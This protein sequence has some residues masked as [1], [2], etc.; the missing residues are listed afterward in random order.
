VLQIGFTTPINFPEFFQIVYLFFLGGIRNSGLFFSEKHCRVGLACQ[1]LTCHAPFVDWPSG[2]VLSITC[3]LATPPGHVRRPRVK[4]TRGPRPGCASVRSHRC[5]STQRQV[6]HTAMHHRCLSMPRQVSHATVRRRHPHA[7]AAA[8][9]NSVSPRRSSPHRSSEPH[10]AIGVIIVVPCYPCVVVYLLH[11]PLVSHAT[12]PSSALLDGHHIASP[13][14][15]SRRQRRWLRYRAA[16]P[17]CVPLAAGPAP[18][19]AIQPWATSLPCARAAALEQLWAAGIS[20]HWPF[21]YF[22]FCEYDQINSNF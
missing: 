12:V 15:R 6:S 8:H 7:D 11:P 4:A 18:W 16:T 5:L 13:R 9:P 3:A 2:V 1:R 10:V 20:A 14:S 19:A 21:K 22:S 17:A